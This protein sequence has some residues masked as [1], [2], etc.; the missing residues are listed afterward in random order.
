MGSLF[1]S[2]DMNVGRKL[3]I[4]FLTEGKSIPS[5]RFSV[6]QYVPYLSK[7]GI[8]SKI[9]HR[10]PEKYASIPWLHARNSKILMYSL[11]HYPFSLCIRFKELLRLNVYD[12]V[13]IQRDL[14]HNHSTPWL[15]KLFRKYTRCLIFYFDDSIWLSKTY[16]GKSMENKIQAIIK[17]SDAIIVPHEYLAEYAR[18]FNNSVY[19][20]PMAIDIQ[21]FSPNNRR[22]ANKKVTLGWSGGGW[23]YDQLLKIIDVLKKLK[24]QEDIEI[25]IQSGTPPPAQLLDLDIIYLPWNEKVEVENLQRMDIALCPLEDNPWTKGKFSI[26]LLQYLAVGLPV[27]CSDVGVNKT[28]VRHELNGFVIENREE[29]FYY[30]S[31]LIKDASLRKKM[32]QEARN[33]AVRF[34]SVEKASERLAQM[35]SQVF[36]SNMRTDY[37][38]NLRWHTI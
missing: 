36:Q 9:S 22:V 19:V 23:N 17:M 12:I 3:H 10:I 6:L 29:W 33:T 11:C 1:K 20:M 13:F 16:L 7:K 34:F 37:V 18:H 24:Q 4:L 15:E 28:I 25:M 35:L 8:M 21:K 14:D 31:L 27:I 30:L 38:R 32:A 26:K 5:T 2:H